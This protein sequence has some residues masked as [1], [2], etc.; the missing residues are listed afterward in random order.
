MTKKLV[1]G[2]L[3]DLTT[4]EQAAYDAAQTAHQQGAQQRALSAL[5]RHRYKVETGGI[6][7]NG[8]T[9]L[10][11]DRSKLMINGALAA[12]TQNPSFTTKWKTPTGFVTVNATQIAGIATAVSAHVAKCFDAEATVAAEVANYNEETIITAFDEEM[13]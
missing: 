12:A 5:A 11:D 13:L 7:V 8:L 4:E 6:T 3:V 10:T 1:N 9:V 2:E